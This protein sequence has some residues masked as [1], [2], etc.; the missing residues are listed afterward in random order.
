[1]NKVKSVEGESEDDIKRVKD[2]IQALTD[3]NNKLID[4]IFAQKEKDINSA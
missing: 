2:R 1:M 4:Q 3:Q